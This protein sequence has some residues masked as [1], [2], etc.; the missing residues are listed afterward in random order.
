MFG[1]DAVQTPPNHGGNIGGDVLPDEF[2]TEPLLGYRGWHVVEAGDGTGFALKS[3]HVSYLWVR[4]VEA[5]CHQQAMM[6]QRP[7]HAGMASPDPRCSC[8]IYA[9]LPEHPLT[10][11][12]QIKRGR[13][14][15]S[16]TIAMW[17]RIIQC[18]R[19]YKAQHALIQDPIVL[20]LSCVK[21]CERDPVS[22]AIPDSPQSVFSAYCDVHVETV[23][24]HPIVRADIWLGEVSERLSQRYELEVLT[25]T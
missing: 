23:T 9:Q 3:L 2:G 6:F 12:D 5:F 25:W 18:E 13:V 24:T 10:E 1:W 14:S 20:D 11:W 19:G 8:G 15:A 21:D 17:G 4:Q 7:A 22:V 16:G